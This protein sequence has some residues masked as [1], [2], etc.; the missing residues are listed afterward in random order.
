MQRIMVPIADP[1]LSEVA[2]VS[3]LFGF[4][5]RLV[6]PTRSIVFCLALI[7]S[8]ASLACQTAKPTASAGA[9]RFDLKGKVVSVDKAKKEVTIAHEEVK[10]YMPAMTMPFPLKDEWAF[11]VL[12]PGSNV[13]ATLVVDGD[14]YWLEGIV[15]SSGVNDTI[16]SGPTEHPPEKAIGQVVPDLT[17]VNQD[18]KRI[19][20]QQ[21][22]PKVLLLT[23][24]YTRCP[25]PEYCTLMSSN[26]A[27]LNKQFTAS[28]L[29]RD[30]THLLSVTIDPAY[31]TPKV[32]R[33]YGAAHT[34]NYAGEKFAHWEF[35]TGKPDDIKR[36]AE[37]FGLTYF[38]EKQQITHS[39][40][41][42]IISS[43]GKVHKV[44]SGNDWRP[45]D[46]LADVQKLLGAENK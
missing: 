22:R 12:A 28:D 43:D 37:F 33:S 8:I 13:G 14:R 5:A 46:V 26:F 11:D 23:F 41:T 6:M 32:L 38:E 30:R 19:H 4:D 15:V 29:L 9:R 27:E 25:L 16:S 36:L 17:L 24:I 18:D 3:D 44:Y 39:L 1:S 31:D 7:M 20:I 2:P 42:A 10:D 21:Y 40:R 35:A 45:A 34:G